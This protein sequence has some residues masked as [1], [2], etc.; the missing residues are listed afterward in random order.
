MLAVFCCSSIIRSR[1]QTSF[2]GIFEAKLGV[3]PEVLEQAIR[4]CFA[5]RFDFGVFSYTDHSNKER[6]DVN[7]SS[8]AQSAIGFACIV[9][10]MV[11]SHIAGVAFSVNPLNSDL[12]EMVIDS[13]WGL[14]ESVV[15]GS[16]EVDHYVYNKINNCLVEQ[17]IGS[18]KE[19]KRLSKVGGVDVL[20]VD[21][22]RRGQSTLSEDKVKELAALV[23]V[24][25]KAY[26][27]PMDVEWAYTADNRPRLL[28]ARPITTTFMLDEN[29]L[30]APRE[31]RILYYDFNIYERCNDYDTFHTHGYDSVL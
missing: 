11:D 24:V 18:K 4:E 25:E 15:D 28:Q 29:M 17:R 21:E 31:R 8:V 7:G 23:C 20:A 30:T 6:H 13:S 3:T 10:E 19:E 27:L 14:G 16:I 1:T 2:A 12:D 9:M 26:G 22:S 5:S